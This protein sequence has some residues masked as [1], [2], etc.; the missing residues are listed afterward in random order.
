M[1]EPLELWLGLAF[2][3]KAGE[4]AGL[5]AD[6]VSR[7]VVHEVPGLL[8]VIEEVDRSWFQTV[9]VFF[10]HNADCV[11]HPKESVSKELLP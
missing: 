6:D 9:A 3:M 7:V 8:G 2:P 1:H 5:Y 10:C 11:V 4:L